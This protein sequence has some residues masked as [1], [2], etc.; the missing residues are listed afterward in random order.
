MPLD[1]PIPEELF[2]KS[3]TIVLCDTDDLPEVP[4]QS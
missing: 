2:I 1:C 4:Q 3:V